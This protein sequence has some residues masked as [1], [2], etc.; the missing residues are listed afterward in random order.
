MLDSIVFEQHGVP[1]ASIVTDVFNVTGRAMARSWGVPDFRFLAM[2]HP[3][4][5]LTDAELDQRAAAI[6]PEV[7]QLLLEGQTS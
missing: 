7:V 2:P 6:V 1:S 3:I 5:N 4:A